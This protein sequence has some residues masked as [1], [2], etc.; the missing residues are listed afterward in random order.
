[1]CTMLNYIYYVEWFALC[2]MICTTRWMVCTLLNDLNYVEWFVLCY[3]I[4][5]TLKD[6]HCVGWFL[7]GSRI[8]TGIND[9]YHGNIEVV[10]SSL[11]LK[12]EN[13]YPDFVYL[14]D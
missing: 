7:L 11:F 6:W 1:M 3:M 5:N 12:I 14:L 2:W 9:L 4:C 13:K 10:S 8:C